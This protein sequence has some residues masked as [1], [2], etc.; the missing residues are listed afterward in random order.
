MLSDVIIISLINIR[1]L[2]SN[3]VLLL[4]YLKIKPI[5]IIG[6]TKPGLALMIRIYSHCAARRVIIFISNLV[7]MVVGEAL[8]S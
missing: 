3:I 4:S 8:V 6:I 2:R 5:S 7:I 1:S